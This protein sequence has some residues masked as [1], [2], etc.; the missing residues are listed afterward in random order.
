MNNQLLV[1]LICSLGLGL[2]SVCYAE[3]TKATESQEHAVTLKTKDNETVTCKL[4]K[5][6]A[7]KLKKGAIIELT[8]PFYTF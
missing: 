3:S 1:A 5:K 4:S 6:D 8:V 2:G 7:E